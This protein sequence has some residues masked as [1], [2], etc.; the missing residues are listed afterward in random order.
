MAKNFVELNELIDNS[1]ETDI[2]SGIRKLFYSN[3]FAEIGQICQMNK[4]VALKPLLDKFVSMGNFLQAQAGK[5]KNVDN[6]A[7][8]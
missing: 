7:A 4:N 2:L 6:R 1:S 3:Q 5:K 8:K